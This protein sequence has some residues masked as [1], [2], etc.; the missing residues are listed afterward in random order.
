MD[1]VVSDETDEPGVTDALGVREQLIAELERTVD[2][3]MAA[4]DTAAA[5]TV[6]AADAEARRRAERASSGVSAVEETIARMQDLSVELSRRATELEREVAELAAL[7]SGA[8]ERLEE[9]RAVP[10]QPDLTAAL[11]P[12]DEVL[13]PL[14]PVDPLAPVDPLDRVE[15]ARE[16]LRAAAE[17][18]PPSPRRRFR[19]R[20]REEPDVPEGVRLVVVQMRLA[21][22][23]DAEIMSRLE[24]MGIEDAAEVI[25]RVTD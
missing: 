2:T 16:Q 7:A 9:E 12:E 4:V 20:R 10:M 23:S 6:A 1:P 8:R 15:L 11:E 22:R 3:V 19:R 24:R 17:P 21:G 13:D 18:P 14:E 25:S 5:R